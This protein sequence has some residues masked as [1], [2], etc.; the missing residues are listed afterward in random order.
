MK[1]SIW[2]FHV[3]ITYAETNPAVFLHKQCAQL[4]EDGLFINAIKHYRAVTGA[5]L[6][7]S[8]A[9]CDYIRAGIEQKR[10]KQ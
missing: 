10:G 9:Y 6:K 1:F 4:I 8:K 2:R 3:S 5:S 7:D